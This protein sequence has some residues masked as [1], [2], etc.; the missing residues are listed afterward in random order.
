MNR[1]IYGVLF[2]AL[3]LSGCTVTATTA[4]CGDAVIQ[5]TEQC[6][7]GNTASGDGCSAVCVTETTAAAHLT[8]N[9]SIKT[10][11]GSTATCPP[12]FDTAAVYNQEVNPTTFAPIGQPI[13]DLFTCS[14]GTGVTSALPPR[15]YQTWIEIADHNNTNVYAQSLSA[16]VDL[17]T[18]DKTFTAEILTDG[19][20]FQL[21]WSL[22]GATSNN[23]LTCTQAGAA[24]GVEAVSTDVANSSNTASDIFTC[25]DKAG[26]T[27][28]FLA[29]TYTISVA[30]LNASMQSIGT[31]PTLTNRVIRAPNKVT[32]LGTI[33]I[34]IT[35]L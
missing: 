6:D 30:A 26:V 19:G 17:R 28:G 21:A 3:A 1:L 35:G 34:P 10:V 5:G 9:W 25:S 32:D 7:D 29:A 33:S 8:A 12:T 22:V 11:A 20:Y 14:A 27:S 18:A 13:I 4:L 24:G 2:G 16:I 31:A 15:V 23:P